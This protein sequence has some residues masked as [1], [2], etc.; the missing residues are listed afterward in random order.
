MT[1]PANTF[2]GTGPCGPDPDREKRMSPKQPPKRPAAPSEPEGPEPG[3]AI[4][5][6]VMEA[7][8]RPEDLRGVEVRRLWEGRYRV[9]VLVGPDAASARVA[10]S[11]F[12]AADGEGNITASSPPITRRY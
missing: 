3:A 11:F 5:A 4:A 6:G 8:G 2:F 7:L 9:N 12:L 10:H 1:G